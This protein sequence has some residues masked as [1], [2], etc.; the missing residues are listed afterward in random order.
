MQILDADAGR[1]AF[2]M[3]DHRPNTVHGSCPA[4]WNI[5]AMNVDKLA[6]GLAAEERFREKAR[7]LPFFLPVAT[8]F[9]ITSRNVD[10]ETII[11]SR[12]SRLQ[13]RETKIR[14]L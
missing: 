11:P 4:D 6:A 1:P 10:E 12:Y 5:L 14:D 7:P 3:Q 13:N 2:G 8:G 9:A